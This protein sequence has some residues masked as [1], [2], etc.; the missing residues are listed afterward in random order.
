MRCPSC[1]IFAITAIAGA[2]SFGA[3]NAQT[4]SVKLY[5]G[6]MGAGGHQSSAVGTTG[7]KMS[8]TFGQFIIGDGAIGSTGKKIWQGFWPDAR[9]TIF[10]V[11]EQAETPSVSNLGSFPNPFNSQTT[12]RYTL[13]GAANVSAKIYDA[14]GA[15][16]KELFN[17][18][19]EKGSHEL[20]WD[21]KG[22]NG[23]EYASGSYM[24]IL[25]ANPANMVGGDAFVGF[26]ERAVL[27]LV[28]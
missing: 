18:S 12:I 3:V 15:L 20:R 11:G 22:D 27:V 25:S 9:H 4:N 1:K 16:V 2:L 19:Q 24:L 5:K 23:S 28:K 10:G 13:P 26:N 8:G 17:G 14:S 7:I 6:V 21:A